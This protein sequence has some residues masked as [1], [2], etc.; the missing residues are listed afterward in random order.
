[1]ATAQNCVKYLYPVAVFFF[2]FGE[3]RSSH[4]LS[5]KGENVNGHV[6]LHKLF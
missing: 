3:P 5:R 1:M 4:L 6:N 2:F